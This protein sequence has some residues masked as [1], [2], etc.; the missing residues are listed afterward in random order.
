M[1]KILVLGGNGFIG[2]RLASFLANQG[3]QVYSFDLNLPNVR[4]KGVYY[5]SGDF[6]DD[7]D[8]YY[9]LEDKDIIYHCI[10]TINPGNSWDKYMQ[11]YSGDFLQTVKLCK[12][13]FETNKK[14]VFL[15]SGGTVY[16]KKEVQPIEENSA[17]YPINHYGA[18]KICIENIIHSFNERMENKII[19]ARISNPYGP[20][21]DYTKGVGFIDAAIK[22]AI[23]EKE[24]TVFGDGSIV[25]DYIYIDDVVNLLYFLASYKGEHDT[26]NISTGIGTSQKEILNMLKSYFP[27]MIIR[28][29]KERDVDLKK[30]VLSN[31]RLI[32]CYDYK[33]TNIK[34][35]IFKYL[36]YLN[37]LKE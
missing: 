7:S 28:F 3:N 23:N 29:E 2:K 25:R 10:C 13:V 20:G 30:T 5:I 35:G 4:E 11:A 14:L 6:F 36:E 19:I 15:S 31:K 18:L 34:D 9:A 27:N 26:F 8:L 32:D 37:G 21:Q 12:F 16:G 17:T 33:M 22:N 1:K 24:I